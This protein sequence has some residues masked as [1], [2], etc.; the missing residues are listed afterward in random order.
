MT[1]S[2]IA[3]A[4]LAAGIAM[5]FWSAVAHMALPLA[6][7]GVSQMTNNETAVLDA[8]HASMGNHS[9]LY[10]FPSLLARPGDTSDQRVD[11]MK[12]YDAKL[13]DSPSGIL[14]YNPPGGH[15]LTPE[16][17]IVEFLVEMFEAVLAVVLLSFTRISGIPGRIV[18]VSIIGLIAAMTTNVSYWNWYHFPTSYTLSYMAMQVIGFIFAGAVASLVLYKRA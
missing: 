10:V 1:Q 7:I 17:L 2:R 14:I 5:Y 8:M 6:T 15:S 9:G 11:A 12:A 16:Q 18:F 3:L 4:A 13:V